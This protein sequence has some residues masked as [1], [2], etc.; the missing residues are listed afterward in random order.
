MAVVLG[1]G[2]CVCNCY[3]EAV[4]TRMGPESRKEQWAKESCLGRSWGRNYSDGGRVVE[5]SRKRLPDKG[6]QRGQ[7]DRQG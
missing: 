6:D 5:Q 3:L 1:C 2:A 4:G 7:A